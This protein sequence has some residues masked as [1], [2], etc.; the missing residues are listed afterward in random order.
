MPTHLISAHW[1]LW[2]WLR[3][4]STL[5]PEG[6]WT[7]VNLLSVL[8]AGPAFGAVCCCVPL[9][10][11][12][13][14]CAATLIVACCTGWPC[15]FCWVLATCEWSPLLSDFMFI[16]CLRCCGRLL[17]YITILGSCTQLGHEVDPCRLNPASVTYSMHNWMEQWIQYLIPPPRVTL[18]SGDQY[19]P[20]L[21]PIMH[22]GAL[23]APRRT[24]TT[25]IKKIVETFSG[26]APHV[27][28]LAQ[29]VTLWLKHS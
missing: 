13:V 1:D 6:V 18:Y 23:T 27:R 4:W 28:H 7:F 9:A 5:W 29:E 22:S 24:L 15:T 20:L 26:K 14:F 16:P 8:G 12:V 10:D 21:H 2:L 3:Q 11:H 19:L 25:T 17:L